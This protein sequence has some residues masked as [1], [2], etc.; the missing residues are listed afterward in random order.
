MGRRIL[1]AW[2]FD[3]AAQREE[4]FRI[5]SG[6]F[7]MRPGTDRRVVLVQERLSDDE[8][9]FTVRRIA[10][11]QDVLASAVRMRDR[12]SF[13]GDETL[14]DRVP[15]YAIIQ[16][17]SGDRYALI[18]LHPDDPV[19]DPLE[20]YGPASYDVAYQGLLDPY[21]VPASRLVVIPVQRDSRPV[22]YDPT[23]RRVVGHLKLADRGGNPEL[24][25]LRDRAE[26][27][28]D[29][30]DTLVRLRPGS[31]KVLDT[32]LLQKPPKG[33]EQELIGTFWFPLDER[34][35][36]VPRPMSGD[37]VFID[38]ATF[39]VIGSVNTGQQPLDAVMIGDGTVLA[40]DWQSR[41][42][43]RAHWK[44]PGHRE[45]QRGWRPWR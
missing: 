32:L 24:Y 38:P 27:W 30:Y 25:F 4:R 37:V 19:A 18:H 10:T 41:T 39:E 11:P 5:A 2:R 17:A 20:W 7:Y 43:L 26:V 28:V 35:C 3:V 8:Q 12:W 42:L 34:V 13:E 33:F 45:R 16:L 1:G 14:W 21:Q 36:L 22:L 31:W 23:Q 15:R 44:G 9:R 6:G 29:D 40:R